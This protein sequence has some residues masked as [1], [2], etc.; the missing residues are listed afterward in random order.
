MVAYVSKN[1]QQKDMC[2]K[3]IGLRAQ[4]FLI[5][6]GSIV[7]TIREGLYDYLMTSRIFT[8]IMNETYI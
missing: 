7:N 6:L 4:V 1:R 2:L 3:E 5:T 8:L